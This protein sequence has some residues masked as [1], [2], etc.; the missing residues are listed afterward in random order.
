MASMI[1]PKARRYLPGLL[2]TAVLLMVS[3]TAA[4]AQTSTADSLAAWQKVS[5]VL[6]HPRCL[7]CHQPNVPKQGDNRQIHV[8]LV[9]R[10]PAGHGVGAMTC[11]SCHN[12]SNN[13]TS[14]TP[15]APHW[16][17]APASMNWEGLS[18]RELCLMLK[19]PKRNGKRTPEALV[20]HMANDG[21]VLWG[22]EA[23]AG[24][25]SVPMP[26]KEFVDHLKVW[27]AGGTACPK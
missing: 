7:N 19:D 10:G 14:R 27:V 8:P 5:S 25:E 22:W 16:H 13:P 11:G 1:Q 6:T 23:G 3:A 2:L 12:A 26:H 21:L 24:R 9:V 15:G 4:Q 17:L 18:D 20:T